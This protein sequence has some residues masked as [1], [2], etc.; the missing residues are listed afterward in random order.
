MTQRRV[1]RLVSESVVDALEAIDVEQEEGQVALVPLCVRYFA[2]QPVIEVQPVDRPRQPIDNARLVTS[3]QSEFLRLVHEGEPK[4]DGT[5]PD[6]IAVGESSSRDL[7]S[8]N[9]GAV[10]GAEILDAIFCFAFLH[11]DRVPAA[12]SDVADPDVAVAR[13]PENGRRAETV[14]RSGVATGHHRQRATVTNGRNG[15]DR[16]FG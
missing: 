7:L 10:R 11:D 5:D 14:H 9:G 1:A 4:E 15:E 2:R 12:D 16:R 6:A 8:S 13:A 3:S